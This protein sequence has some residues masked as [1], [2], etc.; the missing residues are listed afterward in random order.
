[1]ARQGL[2]LQTMLTLFKTCMIDSSSCKQPLCFIYSNILVSFGRFYFVY[3]L[4]N[5]ANSCTGIASNTTDV[6]S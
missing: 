4:A 2:S 3:I 6:C 1:M 5:C